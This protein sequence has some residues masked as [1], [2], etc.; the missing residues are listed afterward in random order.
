MRIVYERA[1]GPVSKAFS[2]RRKGIDPF[3]PKEPKE[4]REGPRLP[5]A[6]TLRPHR[7]YFLP[8]SGIVSGSGL[9]FAIAIGWRY[10]SIQDEQVLE[11]T[12]ETV[13][14]KVVRD[15]QQRRLPIHAKSAIFH[16]HLKVIGAKLRGS[17]Q[18]RALTVPPL[19]TLGIWLRPKRSGSSRIIP[20]HSVVP[21][22]H[23]G[24][25]I[26]EKLFLL[27]LRNHARDLVEFAHVSQ[28]P[29]RKNPRNP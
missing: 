9:E 28:L 21:E 18:V 8:L 15:P 12:V 4:N 17:Y 23:P 2:N 25:P 6:I 7:L 20:V 16:Y 14:D 24:Q 3:L 27:R 29:T 13:S 10:V 1:P 19:M 11:T 5:R 26:S 22:L